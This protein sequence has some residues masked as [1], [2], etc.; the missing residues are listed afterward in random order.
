MLSRCI[1]RG[2]RATIAQAVVLVL[3]VGGVP[4]ASQDTAP[5]SAGRVCPPF[6]EFLVN[7]R[8]MELGGRMELIEEFWSCVRQA[9]T[10]LVEESSQ[11]GFVRA[12]FLYRGPAEEALLVSDLTGFL[13]EP[14]FERIAGTDLWHFSRE[15]EREARIDYLLML[16]GKKS[17]DPL[18]PHKLNDGGSMV[19]YFAGPAYQPPPEIEFTP[20]IPHG[21]VEEISFASDIRKNTRTVKIYLPPGYS[22]SSGARY[23]VLYVHDGPWLLKMIPLNNVF[24][25]LI[26]LRRIPPI[27]AV[28]VPAVDRNLEYRANDEFARAFATELVP[29]ID[30]RYRTDPR[31]E[32]RALLGISAGGIASVYIAARHPAV[33]GSVAAFSASFPRGGSAAFEAVRRLPGNKTRFHL[34]IGVYEANFRGAN[35]LKANREMRDLLR[36]KGHPVQYIEVY[37][38]HGVGNWRSRVDDALEYFWGRS[39]VFYLPQSP[40]GAQPKAFDP[41]P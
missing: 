20:D 41:L 26:H 5:P 31:P 32:A 2:H 27:L 28:M 30:Q 25:N 16:D 21:K 39:Q 11:P 35:F 4:A 1:W 9:G 22:A 19:S 14:V 6:E 23:P 13:P 7:M 10:P 3:L 17:L 24:D 37:E 15:L 40:P 34:N 8:V 33:F 36:K 29:L 38:G 12:V 18:N